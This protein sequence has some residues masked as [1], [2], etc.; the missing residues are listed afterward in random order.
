MSTLYIW[1]RSDLYGILHA[2]KIA[3]RV[4]VILASNNVHEGCRGGGGAPKQNKKDLSQ[5]E[6]QRHRFKTGNLSLDVTFR[7]VLCQASFYKQKNKPYSSNSVQWLQRITEWA[8]LIVNY[9]A[10]NPFAWGCLSTQSNSDLGWCAQ[11]QRLSLIY[12]FA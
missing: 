2:N 5:I 1:C 9:C 7:Y 11:I 8:Q 4:I 6:L 3:E 10:C 12:V